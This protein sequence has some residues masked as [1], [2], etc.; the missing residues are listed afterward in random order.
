MREEQEQG[1]G[2][3]PSDALLH[4]HYFGRYACFL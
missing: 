3:E 1:H 2:Q 4:P